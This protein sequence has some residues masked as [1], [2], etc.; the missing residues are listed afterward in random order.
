MLRVGYPNGS[1]GAW[2][3]MAFNAS[4]IVATSSSTKGRFRAMEDCGA[5]GDGVADDAGALQQC[6]SKASAIGGGA[7]MLP[8]GHF[9]CRQTLRVPAG[10][11]LIG[12]MYGRGG[13]TLSPQPLSSARCYPQHPYLIP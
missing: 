7:V 9:L 12:G 4:A 1:W 6:I 8:A 11:R 2:R 13:I 10:V 3:D 5:V